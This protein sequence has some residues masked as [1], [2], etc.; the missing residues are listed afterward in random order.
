MKPEL[1]SSSND[2]VLERLRSYPTE[3]VDAAASARLR[4]RTLELA[5]NQPSPTRSSV[6]TQRRLAVAALMAVPVAFFVAWGGIRMAP[7]PEALIEETALGAGMIALIAAVAAFGRGRSMLGRSRRVL[8]AVVILTPLALL[9]WKVAV[10]AA[11]PGMMAEWV[12]RP[13]LRCLR[14]SCIL[15]IVPLLG[16]LVVLRRSDPVHPTLLGMAI[17]AAVGGSS[18]VLVDLWCP[19]AYVPHLLLGHVLPLVLA[20]GT[21]A[22]L[23]RHVL[24]PRRA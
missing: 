17:G 15:S 2:A 16:A 22:L 5:K 20:V 14:L 23:G 4:A 6:R 18:W 12:E 3:E 13:G 21:G 19:V 9:S 7:R 10:S 1:E 11:H 24:V 8:L